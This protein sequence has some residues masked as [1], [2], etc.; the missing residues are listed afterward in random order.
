MDELVDM[1]L[2][3]ELFTLLEPLELL[4]VG[5]NVSVNYLFKR[6]LVS[7]STAVLF[8]SEFSELKDTVEQ[9]GDMVDHCYRLRSVR[10]LSG[11]LLR[12]MLGFLSF[13]LGVP[14]LLQFLKARLNRV[15]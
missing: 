14:D 10:V 2:P 5:L 13:H 3:E 9:H 6:F 8:V 11:D 1:R 15:D 4:V 7:L 12:Y